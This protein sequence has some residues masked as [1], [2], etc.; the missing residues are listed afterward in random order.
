MVTPP[1]QANVYTDVLASFDRRLQELRHIYNFWYFLSSQL[2]SFRASQIPDTP[3]Y[4]LADTE[5]RNAWAK[6]VEAE[7]ERT[8]IEDQIRMYKELNEVLKNVKQSPAK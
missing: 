3:A 7:R 4:I 6:L 5:C 8:S 1:S 2:A